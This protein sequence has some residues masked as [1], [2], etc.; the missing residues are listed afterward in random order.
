MYYI[1]LFIT[2]DILIGMILGCDMFEISYPFDIAEKGLA[3]NCSI[4][5][6]SMN[7]TQSN[8]ENLE[9]L[10]FIKNQKDFKNFDVK[11][12]NL[13]NQL[14]AADTGILVDKCKCFTCSN[15]YT[16]AYI[17]HLLK[18]NELNGTILIIL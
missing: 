13:T 16:R 4:L 17:H 6:D 14:F 7:F 18:C 1:S 11:T 5:S 15:G 2:V 8:K 9:E 10:N 3:I 12:L